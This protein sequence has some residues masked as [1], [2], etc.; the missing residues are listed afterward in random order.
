MNLAPLKTHVEP[1]SSSV[2][3]A[4]GTWIIGICSVVFDIDVGQTLQHLH[5]ENCLSEEEQSSVAFHAFP[6]SS[7]SWL[8]AHMQYQQPSQLLALGQYACSGS[9]ACVAA[10]AAQWYSQVL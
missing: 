10:A 6:V 4:A 5:P 9:S 2:G 8:Q 7:S 1:G 3:P